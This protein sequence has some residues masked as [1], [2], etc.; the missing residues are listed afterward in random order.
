[1]RSGN[2]T[3]SEPWQLRIYER[4]HLV[5]TADLTGP[6]ELGRQS[7]AD[8]ALYSRHRLPAGQRVVIAPKDE[9]SVSRRQVLVE[10]LGEA[11]FRLTNLSDERTIGLPDG[12]DLGPKASCS[13]LADSLLRVGKRSIRLQAAGRD[14]LPLHGLPEA[15]VAPGQSILASVPFAE[16]TL[17]AAAGGIDL[18]AVVPW[19]Q[20]AMDVVQSAASSADFFDKAARAVVEL[21][22]LDSGRVLLLRQD[23]WQLQAVSGQPSCPVSNHVLARL[24]QEK[25]TFWEVPGPSLPGA[26]SLQE[27]AAVVAAPILDRNGAV[28]GALYGD[29]KKGSDMTAAGPITEEQA[30]FVQLLARG[31]AAGLARL[32]QEQAA[33]A[34][35]VQFEQFFSP[36]L[37]RQ[38]A[39][40]P[41]LLKGRDVEV[42]VLVCDVR[43]FSRVSE[44]L[45]P[46]ATMEWVGDVLS[47]LSACVQRHH[48]VLVDYVGDE[49]MAMWGA[50]EEQPDHACLA[51]RAAL[52]M[53]ACLPR[54]DERWQERI[55]VPTAFGVG[56]NTGMARVGNSGSRQKF[57]Y[58][59]LGNTVNL[60]SRVQGA[61]K[62]LKCP[63]LITGATQARLDGSF[64]TRRLCQVQ[65]VNIAEPVALHE[66]VPD[67]R[68][69]WPEAK[70]EYEKALAE[71]ESKNFSTAASILGNWR[72]RHPSDAPAL[73][74]LYRAVQCMVEEPATFDP[75]WVLP[76]K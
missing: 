74:L 56:V 66:L 68:A 72:V 41:D 59:P 21:V 40:H 60:A 4:Q 24:R 8:E 38:L 42:S 2:S 63:L 30:V 70:Q 27:V 39:R 57:E 7:S 25:R 14:P 19:F 76:G 13:I 37:S 53:V 61:T 47:E 31:V 9:K 73:L 6:A 64:A 26:V 29:R 45:G 17:A 11:G 5:H 49:L 52:D 58:G 20:A 32:D 18:K 65:A 35:R 55:G 12:T 75:V 16:M 43:G 44:R 50:P 3:M 1:M 71:F 51:C 15:T 22:N 48:G 34:A 69:D 33:L 54:L 36:E 10:P 46:E 62:Y 67:G 23:E 28:I